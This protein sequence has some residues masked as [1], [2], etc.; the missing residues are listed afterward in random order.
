MGLMGTAGSL[1]IYFVLPKM[2]EIFDT[3]K[4]ATAG[5]EAAFAALSAAAAGGD[6]AAQTRLNEV[7]T[8]ASQSSFRSVAILP[9]ILLVVFGAM[10]LYDRSRGGYRPAEIGG[11]TGA[12]A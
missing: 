2:G 9:A 8:V 4:I 12:Q 1:A 3:A 6:P 11:R 5:G 10:W 7:L